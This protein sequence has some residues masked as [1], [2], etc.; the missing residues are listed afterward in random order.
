MQRPQICAVITNAD[1]AL[2]SAVEPEADLFEVRIDLIGKDWP[3]V[4]KTLPKP[5]IATNRLKAEG[6][7]WEGGEEARIAELLKA[8][9]AGAS[10]IDIEL[11]TPE[12]D[13]IVPQIKKKTRCLISHHDNKRTP[14]EAELRRII[15]D[16]LASGAD[17]CKLVTTA[18]DFNDNIRLLNMINEFKPSQIAAFAQGQRGQMSRLLCPLAGG[19][20]TYAALSEAGASA[21]GQLT[22]TQMRQVYGMMGL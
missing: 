4:A 14:P 21:P 9:R 10:I 16:E 8:G 7:A 3:K 11:A 5:W 19:A 15:K 6:G 18:K 17:I 13:G 1:F 2:I 22:V 20:F 12:L